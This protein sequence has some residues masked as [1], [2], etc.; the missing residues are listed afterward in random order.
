MFASLSFVPVLDFGN[1][2]SGF[3]IRLSVGD[4]SF[5]EGGEGKTLHLL[6][7]EVVSFKGV[8]GHAPPPTPWENFE[9]L[10]S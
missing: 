3:S 6:S 7:A 9:I 1:N 10:A 2:I 4:K 8:W 5:G